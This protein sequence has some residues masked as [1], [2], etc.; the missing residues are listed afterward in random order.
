MIDTTDQR[1]NATAKGAVVGIT[2]SSAALVVAQQ[3]ADFAVVSDH[4]AGARVSI[5]FSHPPVHCLTVLLMHPHTRTLQE[6]C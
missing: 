1:V 4:L 5:W 3:E 6:C 2:A